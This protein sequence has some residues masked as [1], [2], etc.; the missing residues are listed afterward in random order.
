MADK[1]FAR[2]QVGITPGTP[3]T[4]A[5][6]L[7]AA[8]SAVAPDIIV[9]IPRGSN[10]RPAGL[11]SGACIVSTGTDATCIDLLGATAATVD[12]MVQYLHS[13]QRVT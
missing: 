4:F 6:G 2:T 5:H 9:A 1:L 8:G 12:V 11:S 10:A 7:S 13:I 3:L